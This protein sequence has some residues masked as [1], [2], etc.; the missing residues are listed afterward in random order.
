MDIEQLIDD[1][2]ALLRRRRK[3]SYAALKLALSVDDSTLDI[4]RDELVEVHELAE[5]RNGKMLVL[6][7]AEANDPQDASAPTSSAYAGAEVAERRLL[8]VMFCDLVG[9]SRL[10]SELDAEDLREV[11]RGY[12]EIAVAAINAGSTDCGACEMCGAG[13]AAVSCGYEYDF[14]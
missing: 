3:V 8:T 1:A 10:S 13:I 14:Q 4:I 11:V 12:Q 5:D 9:S 7:E 6:I 2:T